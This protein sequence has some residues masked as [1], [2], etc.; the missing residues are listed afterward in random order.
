MLIPTHDPRGTS[1]YLWHHIHFILAL[2]YSLMISVPLAPN[3]GLTISLSFVALSCPISVISSLDVPVLSSIILLPKGCLLFVIVTIILF[4]ILYSS[5]SSWLALSMSP[6]TLS[7]PI[8]L[9][10]YLLLLFL[11]WPMLLQLLDLIY[12]FL[13]YFNHFLLFLAGIVLWLLSHAFLFIS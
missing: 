4:A 3:P 2:L 9:V 11:L 12:L 1:L 6:S 5:V 8:P 13:L 7:M 10:G